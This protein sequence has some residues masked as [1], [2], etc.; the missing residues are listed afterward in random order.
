[1]A[2]A[3]QTLHA[4][5]ESKR[6]GQPP[7]L[8]RT[9]PKA[10]VERIRGIQQ[11]TAPIDIS[12]EGRHA[13]FKMEPVM[14]KGVVH[15]KPSVYLSQDVFP[16]AYSLLP[17]IA[18]EKA[19]RCLD[20]QGKKAVRMVLPEHI[21]YS[22]RADTISEID[23][24]LPTEV[25]VNTILIIV[26]IHADAAKSLMREVITI[27][28]S[29]DENERRE[30]AQAAILVNRLKK[31]EGMLG[32]R[33][34]PAISEMLNNERQKLGRKMKRHSLA[35]VLEMIE[36]H[37]S[38][39]PPHTSTKENIP[40]E[41]F[42]FGL[43]AYQKFLAILDCVGF[44]IIEISVRD[45]EDT[46]SEL[47]HVKN[48]PKFRDILAQMRIE[49]HLDNSSSFEAAKLSDNED[50]DTS[51]VCTPPK[52][53]ATG[54]LGY[55]GVDSIVYSKNVVFLSST[56]LSQFTIYCTVRFRNENETEIVFSF[57]FNGKIGHILSAAFP[58]RMIVGKGGITTVFMVSQEQEEQNNFEL[59]MARIYA[60]YKVLNVFQQRID[61][62]ASLKTII[63]AITIYD[64]LHDPLDGNAFDY[65]LW[66][67]RNYSLADSI[68]K[69]RGRGIEGIRKLSEVTG[70]MELVHR[71]Y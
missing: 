34:N 33:Y 26:G 47:I 63:D 14:D 50:W 64:A 13:T 68:E 8:V 38:I 36:P 54:L 49:H 18:P 23:D 3:V 45:N 62:D 15:L 35:C 32:N 28:E 55:A 65:E 21:D 71:Q 60:A 44:R 24:V 25:Q 10:L 67:A 70:I 52:D 59:I 4:S 19:E 30:M 53:D 17:L 31:V 16:G 7:R 66:Q 57:S 43:S 61:N 46:D 11:I 48:I 29:M 6:L 22:V 51:N 40:P 42:R 9:L 27:C 1:M 2:P 69:N 12:A 37:G 39:T 56:V 20:P 5:P 41:G 58:D